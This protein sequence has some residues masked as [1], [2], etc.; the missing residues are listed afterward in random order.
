MQPKSH[1]I[2]LQHLLNEVSPV[3]NQS[4]SVFACPT[5]LPRHKTQSQIVKTQD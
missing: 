2:N 3:Y 4:L 5:F 1:S